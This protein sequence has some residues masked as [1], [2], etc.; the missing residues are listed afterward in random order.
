MAALHASVD[1]IR[2]LQAEHPEQMRDWTRIS[3]IELEMASTAHKR[4]GWTPVRPLEVTGAQMSCAYAVALQL[5]DGEIL[6]TK[7]AAA[8][9][10]R[11]E[12]WHII[13]KVECRHIEEFHLRWAQ[14][15]I[16]TF[17]DGEVLKAMVDTPR[18]VHP[19]LSNDEILHKWRTATKDIVDH[20]TRQALEDIVLNLEGEKDV[21]PALKELLGRE[22]TSILIQ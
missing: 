12:L 3:R 10:N 1:C 6:P 21:V 15:A 7:F 18:G 22:T 9:L 20:E 19:A 8:T 16:V 11:D 17:N 4:G 5:V 2:K 13:E 14:R